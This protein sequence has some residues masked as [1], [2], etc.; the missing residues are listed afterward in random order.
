MPAASRSTC[1]ISASRTCTARRTSRRR[2]EAC[3]ATTSSITSASMKSWAAAR[4]TSASPSASAKTVSARC[5]TSCP[6][7]CPSASRT[8]TGGTCLRTA[9]PAATPPSSISTGIR[10]RSAFA[11]RCSF[12]SS[13]TSTAACSRM[14]ASRSRGTSTSS[15]S[16]PAVRRSRSRPTRFPPS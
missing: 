10:R 8:A 16:R 7:T 6:T 13:P 11:T 9:W 1:T 15:T 4:L 2:L 3:T 5:S 12:P 14:A